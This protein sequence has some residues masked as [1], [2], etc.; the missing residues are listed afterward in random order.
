[1]AAG[2]FAHVGIAHVAD[3]MFFTWS[4]TA[5]NRIVAMGSHNDGYKASYNN[6]ENL[7]S[8]KGRRAVAEAYAAHCLSSST[9]TSMILT[10]FSCPI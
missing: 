6:E 3:G 4:A 9:K 7:N 1:M 8:I 5:G 10:V 2:V